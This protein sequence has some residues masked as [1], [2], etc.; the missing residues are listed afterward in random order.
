MTS[1]HTE[2]P[3]HRGFVPRVARSVRTRTKL[4]VALKGDPGGLGFSRLE[5][6][7]RQDSK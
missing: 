3:R 4:T 7:D 2:Y 6:T 5:K 1:D